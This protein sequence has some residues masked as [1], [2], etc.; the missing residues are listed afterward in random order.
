[1]DLQMPEL[2]G[3]S[4]TQ[5]IRADARFAELPIIAMTAHA[6]VEERERCF[7]AGMNDHVTK[8]IEPDVLYQALARWFRRAP[9]VAAGPA[10]AK[11]TEPS[12]RF[13]KSRAW[14]SPEG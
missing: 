1:M 7:A 2:D 6:M 4:A 9:A 14:M 5:A 11:H 8:P 3:I 10:A 12:M 13:R